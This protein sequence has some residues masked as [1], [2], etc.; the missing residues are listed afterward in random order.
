MVEKHHGY[1][2]E[3]LFSYN[4]NAMKGYHYLMRLGHLINILATYSEALVK[5]VG[6]LGVRGFIRFIRDTISGPWLDPVWVKK[7]LED[8]FQLRLI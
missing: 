8:N 7:R 3:H 2:Y 1:H 5:I 6:E 4:W